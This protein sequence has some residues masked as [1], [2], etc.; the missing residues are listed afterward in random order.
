MMA[1]FHEKIFFSWL[2]EWGRGCVEKIASCGK[3]AICGEGLSLNL[4]FYTLDFLTLQPTF[5][6][7]GM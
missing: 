2:G 6:S 7:V 3:I 1:D 5:L 4:D